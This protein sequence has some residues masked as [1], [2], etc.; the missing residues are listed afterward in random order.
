MLLTKI[1][2][3]LSLF[4][5]YVNFHTSPYFPIMLFFFFSVLK[6]QVKIFITT[7]VHFLPVINQNVCIGAFVSSICLFSKK[8]IFQSYCSL[9]CIETSSKDFITTTVHFL[10]SCYQ[11]KFVY[12]CLCFFNMGINFSIKYIFQSCCSLGWSCR[13]GMYSTRQSVI[14][15]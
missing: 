2:V 11:L 8:Y 9:L 6:L 1:C 13:A 14:Y 4:L 15:Y 10:P 5:Q 3:F 12:C 7:T